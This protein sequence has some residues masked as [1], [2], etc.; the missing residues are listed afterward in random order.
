DKILIVEN[1]SSWQETLKHIVVSKTGE[2]YELATTKESALTKL[3]ENEYK[4]IILNLDLSSDSADSVIGY[5]GVDILDYLKAT[6]SRISV[7]LITSGA[8]II[9]T[10]NIFDNYPNVKDLLFKSSGKTLAKDLAARIQKILSI[11]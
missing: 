1:I 4:L 7:L 6:G 2:E 8:V 5:E 9:S 11:H 10:R 3:K